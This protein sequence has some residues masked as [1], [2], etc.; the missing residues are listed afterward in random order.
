MSGA[1]IEMPN[2]CGAGLRGSVFH[3]WICLGDLEVSLQTL[4]PSSGRNLRE[5]QR[6]QR[7]PLCQR[8]GNDS[9]GSGNS[10]EEYMQFKDPVCKM[11]ENTRYLKK[12]TVGWAS[13]KKNVGARWQL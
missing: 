11:F 4:Q 12:P 1:E 6:G 7:L 13:L 2:I 3:L 9:R 10:I 5:P 8:A